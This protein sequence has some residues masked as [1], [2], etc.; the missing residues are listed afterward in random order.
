MHV[1]Q[2][3]GARVV[4]INENKRVVPKGLAGECLTDRDNVGMPDPM[5]ALNGLHRLFVRQPEA[6][7]TAQSICP[8]ILTASRF[9]NARLIS[10]HFCGSI[11]REIKRVE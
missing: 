5:P 11:L 7:N 6:F 3:L 9:V 10:K 1:I 2:R 8:S 4:I